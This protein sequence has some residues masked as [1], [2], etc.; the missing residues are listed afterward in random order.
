MGI[1]WV[2]LLL[3]LIDLSW[4]LPKQGLVVL[5]LISAFSLYILAA[6]KFFRLFGAMFREQQK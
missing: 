6:Y 5:G 3:L 4:P 2:V 1:V